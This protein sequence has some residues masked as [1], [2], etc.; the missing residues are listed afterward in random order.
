MPGSTMRSTSRSIVAVLLVSAALAGC[1]MAPYRLPSP[2]TPSSRAP[3]GNAPASE[4]ERPA[5]Q[6]TAS[7]ALLEQ[8][9]DARDAGRYAEATASLERALR[10]DPNNPLL[11]IELAEVKAA[12]G[13]RDQAR[14]MARKALTLAAGNS[15]IETRARRLL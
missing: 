4:S 1:T 11:W 10:I 14:E 8:G 6:S 12:D 3:S 9:R 15:S 7:T 2:Q 5:P 13:D